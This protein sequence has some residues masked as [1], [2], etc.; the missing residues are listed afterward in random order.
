MCKSTFTVVIA[1]DSHS[2]NGSTIS[3]PS[4]LEEIRLLLGLWKV[5]VKLTSQVIWSL[6]ILI[7]VVVLL[8]QP[9][10]FPA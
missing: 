7:P 5:K 6:G 8:P 2:S 1:L 10:L 4:N 9:P 3:S